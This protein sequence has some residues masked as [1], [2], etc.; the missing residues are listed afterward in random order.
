MVPN[1]TTLHIPNHGSTTRDHH[2]CS[3]Y[4]HKSTYHNH[5]PT[6]RGNVFAKFGPLL[7]KL[8]TRSNRPGA[9][10]SRACHSRQPPSCHLPHFCST[11]EPHH[12]TFLELLR[13]TSP[14]A[15][16]HASFLLAK[17][18]KVA[19]PDVL[20]C[21]IRTK[22]SDSCWRAALPQTE[23]LPPGQGHAPP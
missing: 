6:T 10:T 7:C 2:S 21:P 23:V 20:S 3:L 14:F 18:I 8:M 13:H 9:Q 15:S 19:P 16:R 4:F 17:S 5:E 12:T 11:S 1:Q 22:R